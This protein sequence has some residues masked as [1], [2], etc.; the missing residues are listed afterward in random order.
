MNAKAYK[1]R[2]LAYNAI[3]QYGQAL[4][5]LTLAVK[6]GPQVQPELQAVISEVKERLRSAYPTR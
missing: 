5:D 4:E 2:G 1:W 6:L 3:G